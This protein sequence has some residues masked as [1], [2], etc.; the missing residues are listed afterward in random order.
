MEAAFQAWGPVFSAPEAETAACTPFAFLR[1]AS[2]QRR[3]AAASRSKVAV[4]AL[5]RKRF[6]LLSSQFVAT[7]SAGREDLKDISLP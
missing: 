3:F 7:H 6:F 5:K 4:E 1:S 2:W